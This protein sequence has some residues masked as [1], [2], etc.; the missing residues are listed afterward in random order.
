M[1]DAQAVDAVVAHPTP[2]LLVRR[3]EHGRVLDP[4]PGQRGDCEEAPVV[5]LG[6]RAAEVHQLVVLPVGDLGCAVPLAGAGRDREAVLE[7]AQLIAVDVQA[8]SASKSSP[9]TGSSTR[10]RVQSMSNQSA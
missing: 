3:V 8:D 10:P 6:V 1:I 7:I 5:L 9:S 4:Q 2:D